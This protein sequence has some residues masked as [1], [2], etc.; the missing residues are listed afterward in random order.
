MQKRQCPIVIPQHVSNMDGFIHNVCLFNLLLE[1]AHLSF[2]FKKKNQLI[3]GF[4]LGISTKFPTVSE[5]P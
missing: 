5:L 4:W 3:N 1:F 2:F